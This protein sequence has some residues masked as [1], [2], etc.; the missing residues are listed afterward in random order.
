M[1]GFQRKNLLLSLCGLN[2]GLCPMKLDGY[3]PGCGGG[4]G[5]QS[6]VAAKCGMRH[7]G[8]E[9]CSQ[10]GEFPCERYRYPNEY[11]S[12][13]T[14][15][16][17]RDNLEEVMR[18]GAEAYREEQVKKAE[19]LSFFLEYCNDG[20]HK[21]FFCVAVNLLE[22]DVLLE[23]KNQVKTMGEASVKEKA[24]ALEKWLQTDAN[25]RNLTLKLRKKRKR[26]I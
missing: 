17:Q 7:G 24:K 18:I 1:K 12:F 19:L 10:C 2:C 25:P 15:Q 3:C 14:C 9:Y 26:K 16:N 8:I 5:N 6:C 4:E 13:I 11:D 22:L 20:R 21:T 23:A